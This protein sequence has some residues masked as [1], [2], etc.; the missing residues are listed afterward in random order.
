M[1]TLIINGFEVIIKEM[2][3]LYISEIA[4]PKRHSIYQ[5]LNFRDRMN[6]SPD[7]YQS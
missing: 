1:L 6:H 4:S 7:N 5:A 2:G 3:I